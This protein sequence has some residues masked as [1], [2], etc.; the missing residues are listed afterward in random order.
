PRRTLPPSNSTPAN[1]QARYSRPERGPWRRGSSSADARWRGGSLAQQVAQ[2]LPQGCHRRPRVGFEQAAGVA[3][4]YPHITGPRR[5][6]GNT[7]R[8]AGNLR[9][10]FRQFEDRRALAG[11]DIADECTGVAARHGLDENL[12]NIADKD[13]IPHLVAVAEDRY[14]PVALQ[15]FGENGDHARIGRGRVLPRTVDIEEAQPDA[16]QAMKMVRHCG[17]ELTGELVRGVN[18]KR[19]RASCLAQRHRGIG[20]VDSGG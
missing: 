4:R 11:T 14:L 8:H 19:L 5:R 6:K 20:A 12:D 2:S 7:R 18:R 16:R 9:Q 17:M 15:T 10:Q 3:D 1:D 13:E